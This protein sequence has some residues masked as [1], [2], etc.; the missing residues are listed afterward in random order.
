MKKNLIYSAICI[1]LF[2]IS[3]N[4]TFAQ[5]FIDHE[6]GYAI[7]HPFAWKASIHRSGVVAANINSPDNKSG[8]QIRIYN[9]NTPIEKFVRAYIMDFKKSMKATSLDQGTD[10]Y[11]PFQGHWATFHSN[12]GGK[13]YFLKSYIIPTNNSRIFVF[14]S[15]LPF[16]QKSS[17]EVTLDSIAASFRLR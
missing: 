13:Q 12:R 7:K 4:S 1:C 15:G 6:F 17:G 9:S 16:A 5:E 2:S 10:M 11:G 3:V 8:L 14:Q